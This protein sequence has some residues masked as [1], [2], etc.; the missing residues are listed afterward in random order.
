MAELEAPW[1]LMVACRRGE[2]EWGEGGE[3]GGHGLGGLGGTAGGGELALGLQ[4]A[5]HELLPACSPSAVRA[6]ACCA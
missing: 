3:Q 6:V 2:G 4:A 1:V 5:V